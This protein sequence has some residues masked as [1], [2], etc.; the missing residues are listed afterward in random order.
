[1]KPNHKYAVE[2]AFH[3]TTNL[4]VSHWETL[5]IMAAMT[6]HP[7]A[8]EEVRSQWEPIVQAYLSKALEKP[9]GIPPNDNNAL[10]L[11]IEHAEDVFAKEGCTAC[12]MQ[13]RQL[14]EWLRELESITNRKTDKGQA[15][16]VC[17][18]IGFRAGID[19][20]ELK[21]A[22]GE[23]FTLQIEDGKLGIVRSEDQ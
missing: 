1:M 15:S 14:A 19:R 12:G 23:L 6:H 20:V 18:I 2:D 9:M 5:R 17:D 22:N 13:H 7:G 21:S 10:K 11:A 16:L 3:S 4:G 8:L